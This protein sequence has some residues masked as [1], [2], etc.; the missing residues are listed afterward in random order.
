MNDDINSYRIQQETILEETIENDSLISV[1]NEENKKSKCKKCLERFLFLPKKVSNI[2]P[3]SS[4]KLA[5]N[6]RGESSYSNYIMKVFSIAFLI[7]VGVIAI[8][9]LS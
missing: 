3:N 5:F 2:L 1:K 6:F 9:Y 8:N 7:V 4:I